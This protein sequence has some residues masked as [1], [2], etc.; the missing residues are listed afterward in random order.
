MTDTRRARS[1]ET[2]AGPGI[3]RIDEH[4]PIWRTLPGYHL[5]STQSWGPISASVFSR[6]A[7]EGVWR[8]DYHRII[9]Y[10]VGHTGTIQYENGPIRRIQALANQ[11]SF[12]PRGVEARSN[13][14]VPVQHIQILQNPETYDS[15]ISDMVRGGAVRFEPS[16]A[17]N[18]SLASQIALTIANEMKGGFLDRIHADALN[19]TLAVQIMRHFADP[20][21]IALAPSNGLSRERLNRVRDYIEAHL[22]EDLS[23]TALADIA[24]LSSYHFSRSFKQAMGVGLHHYVMQRRLERAKTL[25]RRTNQP[26]ALIAQEAGFADQ[27]H[28]NSAF[29]REIGVTPG[30]F[31]AALA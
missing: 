17:F 23:L 15:L 20:S 25:M 28:L 30:E 31:R 5:D 18:D 6:P 2:P 12:A 27:S 9:Y 21:A 22:D 7:G 16:R 24:C 4:N 19:T 10:S 13:I 3:A 8:S 14:P 26:L 1:S 29:R 11:I